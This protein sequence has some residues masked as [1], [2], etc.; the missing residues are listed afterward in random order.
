MRTVAV[1]SVKIDAVGLEDVVREVSRF[2]VQKRLSYLC[3]ANVHV[4]ETAQRD[5]DLA[6]ALVG[7]TLTLPDGAPVAWAASRKLGYRVPRVSGGD[8]FDELMKQPGLRHFFYGSTTETL[9]KLRVAIEARYPSATVCGVHS[10]PF[11]PLDPVEIAAHADIVNRTAPDVVWVGLGAPRQ[12]IW[13]A[14]FRPQ[15]SAPVL[16]GVGAVFD[17][18]AGTRQRAPVWIQRLGCEW[19][20]RLVH[21]PRR[22]AG[23]Y[24]RTNASFLGWACFELLGN[25]GRGTR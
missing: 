4:I 23:R 22:L 3:L 7:A 12:E 8:V 24:L 6:D 10:P 17:F 25:N 13:M 15:L 11:R 9:A 2:I 18:V 5:D 14:T 20:F 1:R 16:V 19:L 21:E